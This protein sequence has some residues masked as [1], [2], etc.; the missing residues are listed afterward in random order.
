[1][2]AQGDVTAEINFYKAPADGSAPFVYVEQP[3]A[4]QPQQNFSQITH[5]VPLTDIRGHEDEYSLAKDAFQVVRGVPSAMTYAQFDSDAAVRE[6][7]YPETER[8]ILEHVP[9]AKRVVI[10]DHTV[11]KH[12]PA[13]TRRPVTYA[14]VDQ[15][16]AA[17]EARVRR[18]IADPEEAER[19]VQ[20]RFRIINVWRPING[21]VES[22][23]LAFASGSST[24]PAD[25]IPVQRRYPTFTGETMSV[26]YTPRQRW[27]Y[28]SHVDDDERILLQCADN[29]EGAVARV[30]HAAFIHPRSPADAKPRESIEVR[31]LVFG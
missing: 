6:I 2:A 16:A 3:P 30:P 21:R 24:D 4:G 28:W 9:D 13:A 18:S 22:L 7:Y 25:L 12:D 27:L 17:A 11:R 19:L 1:M 14:H 20:G 15:T 29:Q 23:P 10:F 26:Q 5:Q 31:A 8:L